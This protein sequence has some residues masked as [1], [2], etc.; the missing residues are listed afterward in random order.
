MK[1]PAGV[2]QEQLA[3]MLQRPKAPAAAPVSVNGQVVAV[4]AVGDPN[5]ARGDHA[6]AAADL[7]ILADAL[8]R[9]YHRITG[10]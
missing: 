3:R 1:V 4:I 7:G 10:R 6:S 5:D 2:P 9:A 8:G